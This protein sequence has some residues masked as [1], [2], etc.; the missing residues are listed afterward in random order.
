[1]KLPFG[2]VALDENNTPENLAAKVLKPEHEHFPKVC[3][4][5]NKEG[6]EPVFAFFSFLANCQLS[7]AFCG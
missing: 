5:T 4:G 1:L 7:I 2:Q 6:H 3:R